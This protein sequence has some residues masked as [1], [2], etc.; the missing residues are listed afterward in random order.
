MI[1][2]PYRALPIKTFLIKR[3]LATMT[4][5]MSFWTAVATN[6]CGQA[7]A[8][9]PQ[10][11]T[12]YYVRFEAF[13]EGRKKHV[14]LAT[15]KFDPDEFSLFWEDLPG[16]WSEKLG[17]SL[18]S[19]GKLELRR[20]QR[21]A[22][23]QGIGFLFN[24][25]Q[26]YR[27]PQP[28]IYF[29]ALYHPL[30]GAGYQTVSNTLVLEVYRSDG[31]GEFHARE[32]PATDLKV[33]YLG[34]SEWKNWEDFHRYDTGRPLPEKAPSFKPG[35]VIEEVNGPAVWA[36][37]AELDR[38]SLKYLEWHQYL[39]GR[40]LQVTDYLAREVLPFDQG[41]GTYVTLLVAHHKGV[42]MPIS[43]P[44]QSFFPD[45]GDGRLTRKPADSD[46]DGIPDY[47]EKMYGL[48]PDN[49]L[50]PSSADR[51]AYESDVRDHE[52]R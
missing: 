48:D 11:W 12:D 51:S 27:V 31:D 35:A 37:V 25:K 21:N 26:F 24:G 6:T 20:S 38:S 42:R 13:K 43:A 23:S 32:L 34:D 5:T 17:L 50:D 8:D 45:E 7:P 14:S 33:S 49:P 19:S 15:L 3:C 36:K 9:W 22:T 46:G 1:E 18:F 10:S 16:E 41:P 47:W 30:D 2:S 40:L 4:L 44:F 52:A 29:A 28:G 39:D